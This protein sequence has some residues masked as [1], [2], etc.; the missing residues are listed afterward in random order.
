MPAS[1]NPSL[2]ARTAFS[3]ALGFLAVSAT[4][5][6]VLRGIAVRPVAG[7]DY[8]HLL[9]TH[10]HTA[11]L[12]WVFNACFAVALRLFLPATNGSGWRRLFLVLQVAVLG[13][14]AS[15]PFQGY[16]PISIAFSA[17]HMG[18]AAVFAWWLWRDHAAV[19]AA[20]AHLK[21]A[22]G[23]M[24][25]SGLGPLA[26]GPLAALDLRESPLYALAIY[27]Y[28]HA[29]YNGWFL[30]FLQAAVLQEAANRR[31]IDTAAAARSARWLGTG[32]VLTFAQSTLWLTPPAWVFAVA[33]IGGLAQLVG[34]VFFLRALR[35]AGLPAGGLARALGGLALG[36][37]LV[38]HL[39]QAAAAWPQLLAL[40]NHRFIVIAF[41]HLVFLGIVTPALFALALR[42][43]WMPV[44]FGLRVALSSFFG[45]VL[46]SQGI[47]ILWPLGWTGTDTNPLPL[48]AVVAA[49]TALA[50][51]ALALIRPR[52][53]R[54]SGG[55]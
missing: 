39:L 54:Q 49:V 51:G 4:L 12:G 45:S 10:S 20:R 21:I 23:A 30:F 47:L 50:T 31:G 40:A 3:T 7:L 1:A 11:F 26:L 25:L 19:P 9:H 24:V 42:W 16:G 8:G 17:L 44:G 2:L 18:A 38:K 37:W 22:L 14:L 13:M 27:F 15:Y 52:T 29:Q 5:G 28:L 55:V 35:P 34:V 43:K 48:L 33:A 53:M 6:A 41:L 36:G 32:L 46:I